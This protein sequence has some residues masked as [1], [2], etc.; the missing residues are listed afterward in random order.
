MQLQ[1]KTECILRGEHVSNLSRGWVQMWRGTLRR[2]SGLLEPANFFE[3]PLLSF[4]PT[5]IIKNCALSTP[6][7][8]VGTTGK[9]L[10]RLALLQPDPRRA[11]H[12]CASHVWR[13]FSSGSSRSASVG[14]WL[15]GLGC[16]LSACPFMYEYVVGSC[17]IMPLSR[18][19]NPLI[20]DGL[21][22]DCIDGR[23]YPRWS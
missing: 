14:R 17:R 12:E 9:L 16:R 1:P 5:S 23:N 19:A 7:K 11:K 22:F 21:K 10:S 2:L 6:G 4:F 18:P 3:W 13:C 15:Q 8:K 20:L